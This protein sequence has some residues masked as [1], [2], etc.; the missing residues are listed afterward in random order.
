MASNYTKNIFFTDCEINRI[1][2]HC[3][4]WNATVINTTLGHSFNVIG[5]GKVYCEN[6]TKITGGSFIALRGDYGANFDGDIELVNCSLLGLKGYASN[7]RNPGF[8]NYADSYELITI[9]SSGF[10]NNNSGAISYEKDEN[11]NVV[12]EN[13]EPKIAK[14]GRYWYWDFGYTCYMPRNV[15]VDNF[16][17]GGVKTT[18]IAVFND[19]I[20]DVF[21]DI[22][23]QY[24]LCESVTLKNMGDNVVICVG[25]IVDYTK[26]HSIPIYYE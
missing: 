24:Q 1:D 23:N 26:L 15:I 10:N 5:G 18:K 2:A 25:A 6:V 17:A 4:F 22:P 9:I 3:G 8:A 19:L 11:G 20:D 21:G 12:M 14:D 7:K 13:G 16:V